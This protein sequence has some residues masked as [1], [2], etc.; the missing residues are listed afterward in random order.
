MLPSDSSADAARCHVGY[1]SITALAEKAE[2]GSIPPSTKTETTKINS[3]LMLT[4]SIQSSHS[5]VA[6]VYV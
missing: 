1:D 5:A 6:R 3:R 2:A 4:H